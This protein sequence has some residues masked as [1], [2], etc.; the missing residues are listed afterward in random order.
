MS[1]LDR[2]NIITIDTRLGVMPDSMLT[3]QAAREVVEEDGFDELLDSVRARID[4]IESLHR[5]RE[6]TV[7]DCPRP[8][9]EFILTSYSSRTLAKGTSCGSRLTRARKSARSQP[10]R[11]RESSAALHT[12]YF[13]VLLLAVI[14][15][16][17]CPPE[18]R[19]D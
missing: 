15:V 9:S 16:S 8:V 10:G 17:F 14:R 1:D 13:K 11:P 12:F 19:R 3:L 4:E 6:L 7:S 2:L 5:T 18:R